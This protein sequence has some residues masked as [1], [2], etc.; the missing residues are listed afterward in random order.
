M[1]YYQITYKFRDCGGLVSHS[2]EVVNA[3]DEDSALQT[4]NTVKNK[5]NHKIVSIYSVEE[6]SEHVFMVQELSRQKAAKAQS[7]GQ[8]LT[9]KWREILK[10]EDQPPS[11]CRGL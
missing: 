11:V 5:P 4:L 8:R 6:V 3:T 1:S 2:M 7:E 10:W 9:D